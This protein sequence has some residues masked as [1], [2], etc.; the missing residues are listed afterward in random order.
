M[1]EEGAWIVRMRSRSQQGCD[2]FK[3]C[4][5][6]NPDWQTTNLKNRRK[7]HWQFYCDGFE[8]LP[9]AKDI[10]AECLDEPSFR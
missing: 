2:S 5:K 10:V 6:G 8:D 3:D 9:G 4:G 7:N 1:L